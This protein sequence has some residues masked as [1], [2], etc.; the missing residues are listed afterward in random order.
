MSYKVKGAILSISE[1]ESAGSGQKLTFRI[2]TGEQYN[3]LLE[4]EM[5]KKNEYTE[6]LDKFK[7]F[8][9][10]GDNVEVEF[11]LKTFNWKPEAEN[12]VFTSLSAWRVDKV[13]DAAPA[14]E[15][16]EEIL[17]F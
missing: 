14:E 9:K 8:N 6:H 2:D 1:I 3:N 5:F 17:P 4:F 15:E 11:N 12:K 13:G 7:Q 10:V 16:E